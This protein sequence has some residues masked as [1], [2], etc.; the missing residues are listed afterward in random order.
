LQ[1]VRA[2]N[3]VATE[4]ILPDWRRGGRRRSMGRLGRERRSA[5]TDKLVA[6]CG[7]TC[8][9]CSAYIAKRTNDW[10]LQERT[11]A[12]WSGPGFAVSAEEVRCD[13][14]STSTGERFKHC[15]SCEVRACARLHGLATCAECPEYRCDK[16]EKL[17]AMIG[18]EAGAELE[19]L[20][21][22][23]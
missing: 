8:I 20:R 2:V 18:A 16:L 21:G 22:G 1:R 17:L 23:P 4:A 15:T 5:M 7:L 11:A 10:A 19:R 9:D 14:C 12:R 3:A 13:G 6:Y